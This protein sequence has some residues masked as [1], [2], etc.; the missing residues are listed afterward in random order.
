MLMEVIKRETTTKTEM[1]EITT[2]SWYKSPCYHYLITEQS[3]IIITLSALV[4][5]YP[6]ASNQYKEYC[7]D[8]LKATPITREEFEAKY[9]EV[10]SSFDTAVYGKKEAAA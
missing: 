9:A 6:S 2:P 1:V 8:A 4:S 10:I 5:T 3:I 7:G